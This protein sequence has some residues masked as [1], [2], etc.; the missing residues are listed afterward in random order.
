[1][2]RVPEECPAEVRDVIM[3]CRASSPVDRPTAKQV[4]Q[5]L[6]AVVHRDRPRPASSMGKPSIWSQVGI[7]WTSPKQMGSLPYQY[8]CSL[9]HPQRG[10][11]DSKNRASSRTPCRGGGFEVLM[12]FEGGG[13]IAFLF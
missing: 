11:F 10:A 9:Q 8:A 12:T 5:R 1:M 7:A 3:A 4:F 13:M 2:Y 6:S